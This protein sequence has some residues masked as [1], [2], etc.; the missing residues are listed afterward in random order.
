MFSRSLCGLLP[1]S[2]NPPPVTGE[3]LIGYLRRLSSF[4]ETSLVTL[5][6]RSGVISQPLHSAIPTAFGISLDD[7]A[8][9]SLAYVTSQAEETI[10]SLLMT[11]FDGK[12]LDFSLKSN[13]H[14]DWLRRM[15]LEQWFFSA[16]HH[17][18][19][20]CLRDE[21]GVIRLE[22]RLPWVFACLKHKVLLV[23]M[24]PKCHKRPGGMRSD[25]TTVPLFSARAVDAGVCLNSPVGSSKLY[26]LGSQPCGQQFSDCVA[27]SL[28]NHPEILRAQSIIQ[29]VIRGE[30]LV[31][32]GFQLDS[33]AYIAYLRSLIAIMRYAAQPKDFE[34]APPS[35]ILAIEREFSRRGLTRAERIG[36]KGPGLS[37]IKEVPQSAGLMAVLA[38]AAIEILDASDE[39]VLASNLGWLYRRV[40]GQLGSQHRRAI[41]YFRPPVLLNRAWEENAYPK[42]SFD[43]R[44]GKRSIA[45]GDVKYNFSA[46]HVPQ[47]FWQDIYRT[48]FRPMLEQS[49]LEEDSA[50]KALSITLLMLT[51]DYDRS[52]ASTRLGIKESAG[53]GI[54]NKLITAVNRAGHSRIFSE[55]LHAIARELSQN[56]DRVNYDDRRHRFSNLMLIPSERWR[57]ACRRVGISS[58]RGE[59]R[60]LYATAWVWSYLTGNDWRQAPSLSK[61]RMETHAEL[62]RRFRIRVLPKVRAELIAIAEGLLVEKDT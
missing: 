18:C 49:D 52:E 32:A 58:G 62:F 42:T 54:A 25:G 48:V 44:V 19:P 51:G 7:L 30:R 22:W 23:D 15:A 46:A 56:P 40:A 4:H 57:T 37:V 31:V 10:R 61:G 28:E 26:G 12:V 53:R 27:E 34:D 36:C 35:S 11:H 59:S 17:I 55:R 20:L 21:P 2:V 14:Q 43:R 39:A 24:C 60:C 16:T 1:W 3:D 5:L 38:T 41:A 29:D 45:S 13:G 8:V 9:R 6:H 47:L 50:R 33:L